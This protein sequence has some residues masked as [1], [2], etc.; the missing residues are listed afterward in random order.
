MDSVLYV[1]SEQRNKP[2]KLLH[3]LRRKFNMRLD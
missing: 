3:E 1:L 2:L